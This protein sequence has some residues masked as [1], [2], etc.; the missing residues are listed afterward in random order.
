MNTWPG[1]IRR[2]MS[3]NE[4]EAWNASNYPGTRQICC[5]CEEPTGR[6]E[7]DSMYSD[8]GEG[9]FCECCYCVFGGV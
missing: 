6:C 5:N 2:A 7:E 4:H 1:N 3:Q 8:D 9:P